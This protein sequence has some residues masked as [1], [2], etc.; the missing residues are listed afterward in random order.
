MSTFKFKSTDLD[1]YFE[2][3]SS[4]LGNIANKF[5]GFPSFSTASLDYEKI[6]DSFGY[7]YNGQDLK[8]LYNIKSK[9]VQYTS[10]TGTVAIPT[11][12]NAIK[13]RI[14]TKQGAQGAGR[15]L[16]PDG[17]VGRFPDGTPGVSYNKAADGSD[18]ESGDDGSPY[19]VRHCA[20]GGIPSHEN[21]TKNGGA[22][23][24]GGKGGQ[25]G[26]ATTGGAGG[27]GGLGAVG[28]VGGYGKTYYSRTISNLDDIR[29]N[30]S[31]I[32]NINESGCQ[33][34]SQAT[35][36]DGNPL[37]EIIANAGETG[38]AA[39]GGNNGQ[40]GQDANQSQAGQP[41]GDGSRGGN[42]GQNCNSPGTGTQER[43]HGNC[44]NT[45]GC[46]GSD[47]SDGEDGEDG[48]DGD[49][50]DDA[51]PGQRGI[52]GTVI[53]TGD[54]H[55]TAESLTNVDNTSNRIIVHYFLH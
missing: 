52:A 49:S 25:G 45:F 29:G 5:N 2:S 48:S 38:N 28:G 16:N 35:Q 8:D 51:T 31:I 24:L 9:S 34:K 19:Q 21:R 43:G 54:F 53:E 30:G 40:P 26:R 7:T 22:G 50:G 10:G 36:E 42:G 12:A 1:D 3:G 6:T 17:Q 33:F 27:Q 47:G 32:Y 44:Y 46:D 15:A 23:G 39:Q 37:F 18:G 55:N 4:T 14:D 13:V 41:G 11:W 20:T